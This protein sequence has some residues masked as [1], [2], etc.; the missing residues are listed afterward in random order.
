MKLVK[1]NFKL[2][3][4][5][6]LNTLVCAIVKTIGLLVGIVLFA[7]FMSW[8]VTNVSFSTVMNF[9]LVAM[10]IWCVAF[11]FVNIYE[12]CEKSNQQTAKKTT[13][14]ANQTVKNTT[15]VQSKTEPVTYS[16]YTTY[17]QQNNTSEQFDVKPTKQYPVLGEI[18]KIISNLTEL[19]SNQELD[20]DLFIQF[21]TLKKQFNSDYQEIVKMLNTLEEIDQFDDSYLESFKKYLDVFKKQQQIIYDNIKQ[22]YNDKLNIINE[23]LQHFN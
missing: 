20:K 13:T 3:K 8:L 11:I 5:L 6:K 2:E 7:C 23:Q 10:L 12:S 16:T 4:E 15:P 9:F 22:Q 18:Q 14:N 19:E 1:K 21:H 17:S